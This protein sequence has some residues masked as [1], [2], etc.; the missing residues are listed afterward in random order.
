MEK[1]LVFL[2]E[3]W[4]GEGLGLGGWGIPRIGDLRV[5][6]NGQRAESDWGNLRGILLV[7]FWV[8][9]RGSWDLGFGDG[10][11]GGGRW[12]LGGWGPVRVLRVW[13]G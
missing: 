1:W 10:A 13:M 12:Q 5:L 4:R 3:G 7:R 8:A 2:G 11:Q 9:Q 6:W